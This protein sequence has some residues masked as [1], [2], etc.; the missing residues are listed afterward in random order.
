MRLVVR[1]HTIIEIDLP[2]NTNPQQT[3]NNEHSLQNAESV[4]TAIKDKLPEKEEKMR[5]Y[6]SST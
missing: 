1:Y 6:V 4:M 5:F 2:Q 3:P